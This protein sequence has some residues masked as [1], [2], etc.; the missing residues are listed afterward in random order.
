MSPTPARG[1]GGDVERL[2]K[3]RADM[4]ARER[5]NAAREYYADGSFILL[6]VGTIPIN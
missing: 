4:G 6:V 2:V 5:D 1:G 3:T